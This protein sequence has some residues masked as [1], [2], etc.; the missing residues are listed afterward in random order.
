MSEGGIATAAEQELNVEAKE[1]A[2]EGSAM[3]ATTEEEEDEDLA[4]VAVGRDE[5]A[6]SETVDGAEGT[7]DFYTESGEAKIKSLYKRSNE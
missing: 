1:A 4:S 7:V 3:D 5:F 6:T 2:A